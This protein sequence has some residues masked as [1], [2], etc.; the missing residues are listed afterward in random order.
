V[1]EEGVR[2]ERVR[3]LRAMKVGED[4]LPKTGASARTLG[5]RC[6]I[7]IPIDEDGFV[8]LGMD[9][10]SVSPPPPENL[11]EHRRPPEFGGV[12]KDPLWE[13][14][15]DELPEELYY[16]PDPDNPEGHGYIAPSRRMTFEEYQRAIHGTRGLWVRM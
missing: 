2:G 12:G 4:G 13:L 9:G 8:E 7:D 6:N 11:P 15:T 1:V 16:R 10:M 5:A 3:V 14:D